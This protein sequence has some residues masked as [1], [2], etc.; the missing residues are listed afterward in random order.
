MGLG[1]VAR[2]ARALPRSSAMSLGNAVVQRCGDRRTSPRLEVE[3]LIDGELARG[4]L[5]LILHD[6]GFGGFAVEC[7]L[8]FTIGSLHDFRFVTEGGLAV[9]MSA[10]ATYTRPVGPRDGLQHHLSGFKYSLKTTEAERAVGILMDAAT[11]PL[12]FS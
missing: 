10:E 3:A 12:T 8:A 9:R 11:A 6:L 2:L 4:S 5:R 7:P 1:S